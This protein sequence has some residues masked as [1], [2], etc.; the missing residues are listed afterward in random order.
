LSF[1][2]NFNE[3]GGIIWIP[4]PGKGTARA[5][6]KQKR[7]YIQIPR[8]ECPVKNLTCLTEEEA[9]A[10]PL[11]RKLRG[12]DKFKRGTIVPSGQG[13][14][15]ILSDGLYYTT[16]F[17]NGHY[18]KQPSESF[19]Q[20]VGLGAYIEGTRRAK[21]MVQVS[22]YTLQV[23]LVVAS[24][25]VGVGAA[26]IV[27]TEVAK[28]A[29]ELDLPKL[30]KQLRALYAAR[31]RLN[32]VAPILWEKLFWATIK[33]GLRQLPGRLFDAVT[34]PSPEEVVELIGSLI[35]SLGSKVATKTLKTALRVI[36]QLV[37]DLLGFIKDKLKSTL[38]ETGREKLTQQF[39]QTLTKVDPKEANEIANAIIEHKDTVSEVLEEL[40]QVFKR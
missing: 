14:R 11:A 19:E 4:R 24:G 33:R 30:V 1:T 21:R 27:M 25:G 9:K 2:F 20:D 12:Q 8:P 40:W 31:K 5:S 23:L 36:R 17:M 15:L 22:E 26:P 37:K 29:S 39:V 28:S 16:F 18:Y 10:P 38:G 3:K 6:A 32:A 34:Q 35:G 7:G 13:E